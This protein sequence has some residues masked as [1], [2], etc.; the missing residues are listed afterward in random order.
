[1]LNYITWDVNPTLIEIFGREIRWYGLMWGIGFLVGYEILLRIL[2]N[3]KT[4]KDWGDKIFIYMFIGTIVGARLGH[5]LLYEHWFD[6]IDINGVLQEGYISHPFNLLK[7]WEGGLS[8]HGGAFG[9]LTAMFLFNRYVSKRGF[10][11]IFDRLVIGVAFTGACIRFG[12]FMNSEIYGEVTSLPWG[13][14]F[15]HDGQ[16]LPAHPTQLY[17]MLYCLVA[18]GVTMFLYWKKK[19]YERR[20]LIFGVFL[21]IIFGVRFFLEFIKNNQESFEENMILNMGQILSIPFVVWGGWLIYNSLK[22]PKIVI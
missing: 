20:G 18:F 2:K 21:M 11:W 7:I 12:N 6:W 9:I 10:I 8:S 1:M 16:T 5:C 4:P 14:I 15:K 3:E 22:K 17:E 19:A 13:V